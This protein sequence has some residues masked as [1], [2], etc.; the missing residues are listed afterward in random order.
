MA[1]IPGDPEDQKG[2]RECSTFAMG[3]VVQG[4]ANWKYNI[5]IVEGDFITIALHRA[6][7]HDGTWPDALCAKLNTLADPWLKGGPDKRYMFRLRFACARKGLSA[8]AIKARS[9]VPP[10][11]FAEFV[12]DVRA[13]PAGHLIVVGMRTGREGHGLHSVAATLQVQW[14]DGTGDVVFATNSWGCGQVRNR[15]FLCK[16]CKVARYC[17]ESCQQKDWH[18]APS[19]HPHDLACTDLGR[20]TSSVRRRLEDIAEFYE[21]ASLPTD[22]VPLTYG[23]AIS[24]I[25]V[26]ALGTVRPDRLRRTFRRCMRWCL[27]YGAGCNLHD[28]SLCPGSS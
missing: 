24:M 21:E 27:R 2:W 14:F 10:R 23:A 20:L 15:P 22:F 11:V 7:A 8:A 3:T 28:Q 19:T 6:Q 1:T 12:R 17:C 5:G 18:E 4:W 13:R 9:A 26:F 16:G 25:K